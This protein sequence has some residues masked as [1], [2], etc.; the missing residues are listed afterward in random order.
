MEADDGYVGLLK[1]YH[2]PFVSSNILMGYVY[3]STQQLISTCSI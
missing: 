1:D 2:R 3:N